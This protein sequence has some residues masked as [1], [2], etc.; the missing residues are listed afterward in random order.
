M[1]ASATRIYIGEPIEHRSEHNCLLAVCEELMMDNSWSCI[2]ANFH[3]GGRQIDLAVFTATTTLVIEA[4]GYSLPVQGQINGQWIQ[5]GP[6]GTKRLGNAYNQA[7]NAKNALRDAISASFKIDGYPNA[8]VVISPSVPHGSELT[9]GD[10]KVAVGD[11]HLLKQL[12]ARPSGALLTSDLCEALAAKLKLEQVSSSDA[13]LSQEILSADRLCNEYVKSFRDF[14][15]PYASE[16]VGDRYEY[17]DNEVCVSDIHSMIAKG[18]EAVLISGPSGCGKTLLSTSCAVACSTKGNIP[19]FVVAKDFS[20]QFQA[21]LDKEVAL[22]HVRTAIDIIRAAAIAGKRVILFMDGYNEC[23]EALQAALTRSLKAF[24]LRYDAGIVMTTQ[25]RITRPDLLVLNTVI[26]KRPSDKLK[27]ALAKIEKDE[28]KSANLSSLLQAATSGLEASIIG[29]VGSSLSAGASRFALFLGYARNRLGISAS[30]GVRLLMSL[31]GM[32]VQQSRFS[33]S[34][35]EFSRLSDSL[36]I[37]RDTALKL[38][39]SR[40]LQERGDRVSF[41]HELYFA[42]FAAEAAVRAAG[43][44]LPSMREAIVSP[45]LNSS[46]VFML[47]AI[48]DDLLLIQLLDSCEDQ[49]LIAACGRGECGSVAQVIINRKIDELLK[50]MLV[51]AQGIQFF[52]QDEGWHGVNI[53]PSSLREDLK[54][55]HLYLPAIA[56]CLMSGCYQDLVMAACQYVDTA[57]NA[58]SLK[59]A[60]EA[61]SKKIPLRHSS[62]SAAYVMHQQAAISKL[63]SF[64]HSGSLSIRSMVTPEF[65]TVLSEKWLQ[66]ETSGQFYFLICITK[67]TKYQIEAAVHIAKLMPNIRK[68]P[69]HLQLDLIDFS[70]YLREAREP[71]RLQIIDA[72][73][74]SLDK[75]GVMMNTMI[76][77]ALRALGALEEEEWDHLPVIRQEIDDVLNST[78]FESDEMAWGLYSRQFD[79][80]FEASYWEEIQELKEQKKKLLLTKACRGAEAPYL[81]FLGILI[82]QLADF[83]DR[84]S[85]SAI[86]KWTVLPDKKSFMPQDAVEVFVRAHEA[87]GHLG[88]SLPEFRGDPVTAVDHALLACGEL[89]YWSCRRDIETS[90]ISKY[91][92]SARGTLLVHSQCAG[93]SALNTV[94]SSVRSMEPEHRSIVLK[95]PEMAAMICR[96]A[97]KKIDSQ[98]PYFEHSFISD[99]VNTAVFSIQVLGE[100]GDINDLL[101]LREFSDNELYGVSALRAIKQIEDRVRS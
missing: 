5:K 57:I 76:F 10:F 43:S 79:H 54:N 75:L 31:A 90:D 14:Y 7:L 70:R 24:S 8:A 11:I 74:D 39:Q 65:E 91:T 66:A 96:E 45:R 50:S 53:D 16:L 3:L 56:H 63:V 52:I 71:Y 1:T 18:Q 19:I 86:S 81:T 23:S 92:A 4:K 99:T 80:P 100:C 33:I 82:K 93:A 98:M 42:A 20:G 21:L 12:I 6:Y 89:C 83:G 40:L 41:I 30:E 77:E 60:A 87:L 36:N 32:L 22:L 58:F 59:H 94:T 72:L 27:E 17:G 25:T 38:S 64:V 67:F 51:E 88:V 2:F 61:K 73:Q 84:D 46:K 9:G 35:H 69:Y 29:K 85:A 34:V 28:V 68:Y 95:Y 26:V 15:S 78:G 62:F 49:D 47:G 48:E 101:S 97:L 44:S 37:G 55:F 13:A